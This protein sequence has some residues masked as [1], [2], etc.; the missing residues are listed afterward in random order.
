VRKRRVS[1]IFVTSELVL[2]NPNLAKK[3]KLNLENTYVEEL[4][5]YREEG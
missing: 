1:R 5:A 3:L 4:D 2:T